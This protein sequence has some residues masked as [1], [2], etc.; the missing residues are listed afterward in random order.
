MTGLGARVA[1]TCWKALLLVFVAL[2]E[3]VAFGQGLGVPP[4]IDFT[5]QYTAASEVVCTPSAPSLQ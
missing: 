1:G 5:W 3:E 4:L 2:E